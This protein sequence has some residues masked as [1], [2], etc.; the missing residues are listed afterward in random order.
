MR[1]LLLILVALLPAP[2]RAASDARLEEALRLAREGHT[3]AA[4]A[5]LRRLVKEQPA[6]QLYR[7]NLANTYYLRGE[8]K[9]AADSF[10]QVALSPSPLRL[11][12]ALFE[13]RALR[14]L[15]REKEAAAALARLGKEA[16]PPALARAVEE[17]KAQLPPGRE[18]EA[19]LAKLRAGN[20]AEAAAEFRAQAVASPRPELYLALAVAELRA[21]RPAEAEAALL[22]AL[23][24]RPDPAL[25]AEARALLLRVREGAWAPARRLHPEL[26]L[27][28][29]YDSNYYADA[30]NAFESPS[31]KAVANAYAGA[32][33]VLRDRDSFLWQNR[34]ALGWEGP[35]SP[36]AD[37]VLSYGL[38]TEAV[39]GGKR[40]L[41]AP[42]LRFDH[43]F[44][45]GGGPYYYQP[46]AALRG[47]LG[48][49]DYELGAEYSFSRP[50][51]AADAYAF[52]SGPVHEAALEATRNEGSLA[53]GASLSWQHVGSG[54]L[55][56][57]TDLMPLRHQGLGPSLFL[58]L[59]PA[60]AWELAARLSY[61]YRAY[62]TPS[63]PGGTLRRDHWKGGSLE[64]RRRL[65]HGL[66]A[67]LGLAAAFNA[68][69]LGPSGPDDKNYRQ[70][71]LLGGLTWSPE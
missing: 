16:L 14:R 10:R 3:D 1:T 64:A 50:T 11:P 8:L 57:G 15:G 45:N 60:P 43:Y 41:L 35:V 21:S 49:G 71:S 6:N 52:V 44:T 70:L 34:Y 31:G 42:S 66:R 12:A 29:G 9:A 37:R 46:S 40:G 53:Y 30:D 7:F 56:S 13:A 27:H 22:R 68:S 25:E 24:L 36:G 39:L 58:R 4:H 47:R 26:A 69:T 38:E 33:H 18:S 2:L 62:T 20:A 48:A 59:F 19:A 54:D 61:R 17:E 55:A 51:A 5:A 23:S 63:Q 32:R 67:S 65:G 28:A